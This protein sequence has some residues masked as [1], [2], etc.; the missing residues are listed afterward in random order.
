MNYLVLFSPVDEAA[1]VQDSHE[2]K[3]S[4]IR[5]RE[6]AIEVGMKQFRF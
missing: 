6:K 3:K 2:E 1:F 5:E 4:L